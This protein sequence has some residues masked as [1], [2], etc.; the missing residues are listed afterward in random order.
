MKRKQISLAELRLEQGLSQREFARQINVSSATIG[1]YEAGRR[2]PSLDKALRISAYFGIPIENIIFASSD[3]SSSNFNIVESKK[4][5][6]SD[7]TGKKK[8]STKQCSGQISM[9]KENE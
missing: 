9:F 3:K 2:T 7:V 1:M 6:L 8:Y 5:K 4:N